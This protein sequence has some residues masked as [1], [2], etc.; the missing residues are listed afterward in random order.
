MRIKSEWCYFKFLLRYTILDR[1]MLNFRKLA[2]SG[3]LRWCLCIDLQYRHPLQWQ[4]HLKTSL[5]LH[6]HWHLMTCILTTLTNS[7]NNHNSVPHNHP[8]QYVL[9]KLLT[10]SQHTH[11]KTNSKVWA[12]SAELKRKGNGLAVE[13]TSLNPWGRGSIPHLGSQRSSFISIEHA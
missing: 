12:I 9:L 5:S 8:I 7:F 10:V 11:C 4:R 3:P 6:Y 13:L 2:R 1:S